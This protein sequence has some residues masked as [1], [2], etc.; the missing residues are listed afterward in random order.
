MRILL[1]T[2]V[3]IWI[4]T[5]NPRI[6]GIRSIIL[7]PETDVFVSVASYWEIAI[8]SDLGKLRA[9]IADARTG[10]K[11]SGF[12]ELDIT[13]RHIEAIAD[14]LFPVHHKDPFDRLLIAQAIS[15]PMW[16]YTS[17]AILHRY[18]PNHVKLM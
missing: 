2:N 5:D 16:L 4:V 6:D 1:D 13:A 3:L 17:D 15:E 7:S 9:S 18:A 14:P 12:N 8:K 10:V 11:E